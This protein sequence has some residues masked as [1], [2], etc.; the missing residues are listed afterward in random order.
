MNV[1]MITV[2]GKPGQGWTK[3]DPFQYCSCLFSSSRAG[4]VL[5]E[6]KKKLY[7]ISIGT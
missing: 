3:D 4:L 1:R 2:V 5:S 7:Y 6:K